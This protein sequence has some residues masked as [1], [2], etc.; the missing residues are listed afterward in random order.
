MTRWGKRADIYSKRHV[1]ISTNQHSLRFDYIYTPFTQ[2]IPAKAAFR[3]IF[4]TNEET[5]IAVNAMF[6]KL[7]VSIR[8]IRNCVR[9]KR[10]MNAR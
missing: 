5:K 8:N 4:R 9:S 6:T 1:T 2:T 10:N 7:F 3:L